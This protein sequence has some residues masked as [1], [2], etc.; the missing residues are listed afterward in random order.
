ME[1]RTLTYFVEVV[2]QKSMH[3]AAEELYISQPSLSRAIQSL[4]EE[5]GLQLLV[6]TNRGVVP[7]QDGENVFY[8][9]KT[10][11]ERMDSLEKIR[12]IKDTRTTTSLGVAVARVILNDDLMLQYR[13]QVQSDNMEIRIMET[14]LEEALNNVEN[15]H[16]DIGLV[17]VNNFQYP[18]LKKVLQLK[19]LEVHMVR[20]SPICVCMNKSN[21][22]M[23]QEEIRLE[24]LLGAI[25][26]VLPA[27]YF[28]D[29]NYSLHA[30]GFQLSD[31]KRRIVMNN[32]HS[33][34]CMLR[35]SES[36]TFVGE[37]EKEALERGGISCKPIRDYGG[38]FY[39]VWI[40]RKRD[41]LPDNVEL[42]LKLLLENY[43]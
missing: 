33:I 12:E 29:M 5:L 26:I 37:W 39:L 24:Q 19:E 32:Y 40:K 4:E 1:L 25:Q 42:F 14:A 22:L 28:S 18:L 10:I 9:A 21:P 11:K 8:Y 15:L 31:T 3:K 7:T 35:H 6:R 16:A 13:Q 20:K 27:D 17:M 38:Q 41:I 23:E 36:F 43:K 2:R 34:I 30:G